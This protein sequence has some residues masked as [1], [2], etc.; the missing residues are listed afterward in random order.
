MNIKYLELQA[1]AGCRTSVSSLTIPKQWNPAKSTAPTA[2]ARWK[3]ARASSAA[4]AAPSS[5]WSA[6]AVHYPPP[7]PGAAGG[8]ASVNRP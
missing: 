2:S 5:T 4:C 8:A 7:T 1:S 3:G 6:S